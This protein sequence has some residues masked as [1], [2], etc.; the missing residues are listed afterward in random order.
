MVWPRQRHAKPVDLSKLKTFTVWITER[1]F[2]QDLPS[3]K[4]YAA[5]EVRATGA[6]VIMREY[7]QVIKAADF[8]KFFTDEQQLKDYVLRCA[9]ERLEHHRRQVERLEEVLQ[10]GEIDCEIVPMDAGPPT[11]KIEL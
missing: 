1:F 4:R 3:I 10:K 8:R 6:T 9:S 11:R 5:I 2:G 7:K